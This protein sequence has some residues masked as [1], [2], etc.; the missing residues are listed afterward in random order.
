[1]GTPAYMAPE[2]RA[3][4]PVDART[5]IYAFGG[6]LYEM[7]TGARVGPQRK[8]IGTRRLEKIV[9]RCLEEDAGRRWQSAAQLQRA[10]AGVTPPR[11][12]TRMAVG[13]A[14][15]VTLCAAGYLYSHRAPKLITQGRIVLAEFENRTGDAVFDETLRQGLAV[16]LEQSPFLSL[17]SDDSIR[18]SLRFMNRSLEHGEGKPSKQLKTVRWAAALR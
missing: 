14:T 2:Q 10:L 15:I 17:V 12:A 7:L 5:D 13:A 6:V 4:E 18:Q 16:Q 9:I 11:R 1:M 8:R 3:G